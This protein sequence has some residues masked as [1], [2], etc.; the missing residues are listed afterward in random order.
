MQRNRALGHSRV[1]SGQYAKSFSPVPAPASLKREK[2]PISKHS[3]AKKRP[4]KEIIEENERL[5]QV[6][7]RLRSV[8]FIQTFPYVKSQYETKLDQVELLAYLLEEVAEGDTDPLPE[9]HT[10]TEPLAVPESGPRRRNKALKESIKRLEGLLLGLRQELNRTGQV[11]D[12]LRGTLGYIAMQRFG[13]YV[14]PKF[15]PKSVSFSALLGIYE[16]VGYAPRGLPSSQRRQIKRTP[17]KE[18]E[19]GEICCI[20]CEDFTYGCSTS[21]LDCGHFFHPK[22]IQEWVRRNAVCPLCITAIRV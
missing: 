16:E 13:A 21:R 1:N 20:C 6:N 4:L 7:K 3:K 12:R 17:A 22:C 9:F 10:F 5:E 2:S 15:H 19:A 11:F 18:H 8:L 14:W